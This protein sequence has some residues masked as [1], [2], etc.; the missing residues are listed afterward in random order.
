ME[1]HLIMQ[2]VTETTFNAKKHTD[3]SHPRP[4]KPHNLTPTLP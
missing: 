4:Q 3:T 2:Q 1:N